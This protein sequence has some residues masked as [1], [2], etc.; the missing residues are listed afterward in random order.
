MP[1]ISKFFFGFYIQV[2]HFKTFKQPNILHEKLLSNQH[3]YFLLELGKEKMHSIRQTALLE[4]SIAISNQIYQA[5]PSPR[6]GSL[7]KNQ[8]SVTLVVHPRNPLGECYF[9]TEDP[10]NLF[11]CF[12][13]NQRSNSNFE[14]HYIE[15]GWNCQ[16]CEQ[17][18]YVSPS[19]I[20]I[21]MTVYYSRL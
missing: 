15:I 8:C 13:S 9:T 7:L 18:K 5:L 20:H 19:Y 10:L 16:R 1:T 17:C 12:S 21:V 3:I 14:W 6:N 11:N 4:R 2:F